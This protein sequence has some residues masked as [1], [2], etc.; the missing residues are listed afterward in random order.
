MTQQYSNYING[1]WLESEQW[2]DNINPSNLNETIGQYAQ[3]TA[4]QAQQAIAAAHAA[5]DAWSQSNT[6][7]EPIVWIPLAPKSL[8]ASRNWASY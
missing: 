1:Q 5:F 4:E 8:T 6:L 3:A 2:L 7:P